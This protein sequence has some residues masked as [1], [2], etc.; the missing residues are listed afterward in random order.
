MSAGLLVRGLQSAWLVRGT[1]LVVLLFGALIVSPVR[2][3]EPTKGDAKKEDA[4][5]F[6]PIR[7]AKDCAF[8][9]TRQRLYVTTP[10]QLIIVDTK[11]RKIAES[12]DLAG[13]LQACDISPDFKFLAIAPIMAQYVYRIKLD[14]TKVEDLD[15]SQIKFKGGASETGVF[16][17]CVGSD[18]SVLFSTTFAGS[19]GVKLRRLTPDDKVEEVGDVNMDSVL[20]ASG[21]RR[22]AAVAEGN[23]SSGPLKVYDFKEQKLNAVADLQGFNYEMACARGANYFAR[24]HRKGCDLY[25]AKGGRLG[26]L[27]GFPVI[28]AAFH[29]KNDALFVMRHREVNI[30]EYDIQGKKVANAY[31][32]DKPLVIRGDVSVTE[33]ADL[34][35]VGRDTVIANFRTIVNINFRTYQSGR[36]KIAENGASL[37]AVI[38]NGVYMFPI[39]AR[40]ASHTDSKPKPKIKVIDPKKE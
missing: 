37:F 16:S 26:T 39:K 40:P 11:N 14:W 21:D 20:T 17:L 31:P 30:Q 19:G 28:C 6:F 32:L 7:G 36:L 29:P 35:P 5:F 12:I 1:S 2:G 3:A 22:Y 24:P 10:K 15:I 13:G 27:E 18:D 8:D 34:R 9:Q 33:V 38:R 4:G 25:D 23:I